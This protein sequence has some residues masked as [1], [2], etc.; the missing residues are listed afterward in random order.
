[1]LCFKLC[2]YLFIFFSLESS[3]DY[4]E[5]KKRILDLREK[6]GENN[7]LSS[8]AGAFVQ[9]IMGLRSA[10]QLPKSQISK[11][12][13][14][15]DI[16]KASSLHDTLIHVMDNKESSDGSESQRIAE[17]T[18]D[19]KEIP[20][21]EMLDNFSETHVAPTIEYDPNEGIAWVKYIKRC[22]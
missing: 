10:S 8:H 20:Q 11:I 1:M 13:T 16:N 2:I 9:D 14:L 4:L 22:M 3:K 5:T 21:S 18:E 17:F 12:Q 7:W 6:F 19:N 15:A